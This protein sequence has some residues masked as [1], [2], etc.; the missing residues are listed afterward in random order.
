VPA[1]VA[2]AA[3]TAVLPC[4]VLPPLERAR[5]KERRGSRG[6]EIEKR[7]K[8]KKTKFSAVLTSTAF[9]GFLDAYKKGTN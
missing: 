7:R 3:S 2:V 5:E 4:P 9:S 6:G 1:V 8:E